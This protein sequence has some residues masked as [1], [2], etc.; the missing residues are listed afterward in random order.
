MAPLTLSFATLFSLLVT[1]LPAPK[2]AAITVAAAAVL[3]RSPSVDIKNRI[4][5]RQYVA[6]QERSL[7]ARQLK[8]GMNVCFGMGSICDMSLDLSCSYGLEGDEWYKC[9]CTSGKVSLEA[10]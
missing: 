4:A 5:F 1:A 7:V 3:P 6:Y 9:Y 8:P 2:S 10:A